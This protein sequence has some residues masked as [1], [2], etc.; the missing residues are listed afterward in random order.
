MSDLVGKKLGKYQIVSQLGQG[1][2]AEVY[3]AYHPD[4]ERYVAIKLL[5]AHVNAPE[6]AARFKR[7]AAAIAKLRHPNIVQVYDFD[8]DDERAYMVMEL[9]EGATFQDRL[10]GT[11]LPLAE[12][13]SVFSQLLN[14]V[15][16]AHANNI[17][18][19]DLKPANI[20]LEQQ[21][22]KTRVILTDFGIARTVGMN[23][24]TGAIMGTPAYMSP[25]QAQGERGDVRSDIYSLGIILYEMAAG[26]VPFIADHLAGLIL[27]HITETPKPPSTYNPDLPSEIEAAILKALSKLPDDRFQTVDEMRAAL[28]FQELE[29]AAFRTTDIPAP[30]EPPYKGLQFFD[31]HDVDLFFGRNAL[32]EELVSRLG[33]ERFLAVVGASGS[34]KSSVVRAGVVPVWVKGLETS[35]GKLNHPVHII[36]PTAHPLECLAASLTRESESVSATATL[37]DD[38]LKD[39]RS[40]QLYIRKMLNRSGLNDLLLVVDQFEEVFTLCKDPTERKAFIENLI[41]ATSEKV[42]SP[43]RVVITLRADFYQHCAEHEGLRQALQ[44]HQ[45]FIGAMTQAELRDV[46]EA[47]AMTN[48]WSLQEGLVDLIL[49]DVGEEPGALPLL[50]HALLETWKRRQGRT[51]TLT[52]YNAVG[53]VRKAIAQTAE[54]VYERLQPEEQLIARN[55]FLRLT[56][57]GEGV[58]DSRRRAS[59]EELTPTPQQADITKSVL[60]ALTDARLITITQDSVEV[61]HE[62][63]IREWPTLRSWLDEDREK[64]RLHRHLTATATEWERHSREASELY[65]GARLA[66][67]LEW[68]T[69]DAVVLS[70]L[71]QAFLRA[72]QNLLKRKQ[73]TTQLR[74]IGLA[75]TA[76]FV[77]LVLTL[78]I[79]GELNPW[80]YRPLDM[81]NYWVTIPAGPFQMG[82][83]NGSI[84]EQP[85]RTVT[86][87][88]FQIGRYE[89][90]NR[91][92]VQCVRA[93]IC[94]KSDE[95]RWHHAADPSEPV[96]AIS[97]F[98]ANT[99]C[100]WLDARLPTEAQWE[101]A[102]RGGLIG[103]TYPWG[104]EVPSCQPGASNGANFLID[105]CGLYLTNVGTYAPN[106]YGLYDMAGN[107]WE[108]TA[109]WYDPNYYKTQ[110]SSNPFGPFEAATKVLRGGSWN[111]SELS[112]RV[113]DR[114]DLNPDLRYDYV[115][116]RC[117]K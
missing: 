68:L 74:W 16:F 89:V 41:T 102:A 31:E 60:K 99:Y 49:Q 32:T 50:S 69:D 20:L 103:K 101:K 115:G 24:E 81:Q 44:Q 38:L 39:A 23:T 2:M 62:A 13:R 111:Y 86:L 64:L 104:D 112:L 9:I 75:V 65:S 80:I 100:S 51:L 8:T 10:R 71:E 84:D 12:I 96:I 98:D 63:L 17:V 108:W 93:G 56:E 91:Q 72:S 116:F 6:F 37:M 3:K 106:G 43:I 61:A 78:A 92:Y 21:D 19:R 46:I 79:T 109:D 105:G 7:E 26:R 5:H 76:G 117:A 107:V 25:E 40:L 53:G 85:V 1:G 77:V 82:S 48:G 14:A 94:N 11:P 88:A 35:I 47:P 15:A 90:T 22:Q 57:L 29:Q 54:N 45:A 66:Q 95:Q 52:G 97:W 73:R 4:L 27:K 59:L 42:E 113:S 83:A 36:T 18:H 70:P 67:A 33:S 110:E 114:L 28:G 30:G 87:D 55:I 34:G 58:Q